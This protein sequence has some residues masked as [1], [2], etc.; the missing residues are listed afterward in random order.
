L[1]ETKQSLALLN[2]EFDDVT[3]D[4]QH[5]TDDFENFKLKFQ[6]FEMKRIY[7]YLIEIATPRREH[8]SPVTPSVCHTLAGARNLTPS[9]LAHRHAQFLN[10][11][12]FRVLFVHVCPSL[13]EKRL[14][15]FFTHI[16]SRTM[17]D[18]RSG[19]TS[20]VVVVDVLWEAAQFTLSSHFLN[21]FNSIT[22]RLY[23][24]SSVLLLR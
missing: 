23:L 2:E 14:E 17:D 9:D 6:N 19:V 5:M 22:W 20:F 10:M 1:D 18:Q 3:H 13:R 7:W 4:S 11:R 24:P 8:E 16:T 12:F 15:F 21:P